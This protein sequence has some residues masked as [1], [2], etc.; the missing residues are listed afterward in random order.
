MVKVVTVL[1][2][3]VGLAVIVGA[4]ALLASRR[5]AAP[6]MAPGGSSPPAPAGPPP[7]GPVAGSTIPAVA[8]S[9]ARFLLI[10]IAGTA[11]IYAVMVLLGL[12]VVHA[13]PAVDKPVLHWVS[14]QR[15]H[16]WDRVMT[17]ATKIGDTWTTRAA[18]VTAAVCLAVAWR[19]ARWLPPVAVAALIVVWRGLTVAIH[20]TIPRIGPP[21]H[22]DGTFPSGGSARAIAFYGLIAYLLWREFSGS[23]RGAIWAGAV[24]AALGF[25][26]GYS[27]LYLGMHWFTDVPSGWLYGCMLLALFITAVRLVAGPAR[28][29]T[30]AGGPS[31]AR[32]A[33]APAWEGPP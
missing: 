12:I 11:V 15:I 33:T 25:N 23:R 28:A 4:A 27:R 32:R 10:I 5:W 26:E 19:R 13:G 1:I 14:A 24:V 9:A 3:P 8:R 18:V 31:L 17:Q 16:L 22:P 6:A 20:H 21:G 30:P 29:P 7:A 2:W